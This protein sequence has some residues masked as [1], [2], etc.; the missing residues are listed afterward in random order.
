MKV[1]VGKPSGVNKTSVEN[2]PTARTRSEIDKSARAKVLQ[3]AF[4][5]WVLALAFYQFSENTA[6]PDLWGHVV[7]GQHMLQT[8]AVEKTEIYSWTARGRPFVNHEFGADVILGAAH[9]LLGGAGILLLKMSVGLLTFA[10]CLK[11][12]AEE[13]PWPRRA[14]AW[15]FGALAVVEISYGFAARPQIFTAL[16]LALELWLLRRVHAGAWR[17]ALALP[18][19]FLFWINIHGGALAGFGLL[20]LSTGATSIEQLGKRQR[21]AREL[22]E[23]VSQSGVV[24]S[25]WIAMLAAGGT[26][27]C[28][29][30]GGTLLRWLVDSVL[31]LRPEIEEW[32]PP[33]LNWDHARSRRPKAPWEL[34]GCAAFAVLALR[35]VRN[36]PL[37][38]IVALALAPRHLADAASRFG[39]YFAHWEERFHHSFVQK[40]LPALLGA[41]SIAIVFAAFTLH[42]EHP[43]TMEAPCAQYPAAAIHFIREHELRGNLLVFFDWG[44]LAIFALPDCAPSIDGRLDAC[45]TRPL[46]TAHWHLYNAEPVDENILNLTNADLALLPSK[47]AG[48]LALARRP[49][50]KPVYFDDLAAVLVRGN[51]DRFP[52]LRSLELPVQGSKAAI[53]GRATFPDAT[54]RLSKR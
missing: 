2:P 54:A 53:V 48:A 44:D 7:F 35:S 46:V 30:W 33:P 43:L 21:S 8:G 47:L 22:S 18:L 16:F 40:I 41:C 9:G 10:L 20:L 15:A 38:S 23:A 17:W 27:F 37:F 39:R 13:M 32:N 4:C 45:Y 34:A 14:V 29:P 3:F 49:D 50:W 25:L 5:V 28:N 52:Q 19:L 36:T 11:L 12:G 31:W 51:V 42:K 1:A 24:A 26:L 6:D